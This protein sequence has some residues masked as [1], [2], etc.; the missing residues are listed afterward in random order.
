[1]WGPVWGNDGYK[2]GA[3]E[4]NDRLLNDWVIDRGCFL[5]LPSQRPSQTCYS[6]DILFLFRSHLGCKESCRLQMQV[7][8]VKTCTPTLHFAERP[9]CVVSRRGRGGQVCAA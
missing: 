9:G 3:G 1:M 6:K 4:K 7:V 2:G 5:L 8:K